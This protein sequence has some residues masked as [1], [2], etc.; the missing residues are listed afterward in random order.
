MS[1]WNMC[2]VKA[3]DKLEVFIAEEMKDAPP[4]A[5]DT[6]RE[7]VRVEPISDEDVMANYYPHK[8]WRQFVSQGLPEI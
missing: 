4:G 3:I 8:Y 1:D 5:E 2:G 7:L 6:L